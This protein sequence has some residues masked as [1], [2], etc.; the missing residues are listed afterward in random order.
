MMWFNKPAIWSEEKDWLHMRVEG[1]TDFWRVTHYDFVR[2]TGHFYYRELAGDFVASVKVTGQY[3]NQYD[4]AGLMIRLD[5]RNWIKTGIEFVDEQQQVSAVVT[6]EFS[7][8]SVCPQPHNPESV[9]VR[10]TRQ[11]DSVRIDYSFDDFTYQMLRLAYF[12]A[13]VPVQI[14]PMAAAPDGGGFNATFEQFS[15]LS[16]L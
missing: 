8:W 1:D 3:K 9:Y 13:D 14:G 6:R 7:D 16:I 10:L 4:Q 12:P 11:Y 5:D 15:V 2:D